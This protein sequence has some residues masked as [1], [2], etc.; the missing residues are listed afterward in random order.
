MLE[1]Y[2]DV[3]ADEPEFLAEI[4]RQVRLVYPLTV[5][6]VIRHEPDNRFVECAVAVPA[7]FIITVNTARG[8]FDRK[9]YDG[10][11][12][13][14]PGVWVNSAEAKPFINRLR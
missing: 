11:R 4:S 14:S 5:L 12:V 13:M 10:V 2:A 1:E 7:D 8:H 6:E 9:A 3:L